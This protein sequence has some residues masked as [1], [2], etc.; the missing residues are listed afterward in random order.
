MWEYQQWQVETVMADLGSGLAE[1]IEIRHD[2][3]CWHVATPAECDALLIEH[4]VDPTVLT[5]AVTVDDGCE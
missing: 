2:G 4:G 1:W 5:E 3:Q